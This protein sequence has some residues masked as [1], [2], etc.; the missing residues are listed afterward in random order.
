MTV[1][2]VFFIHCQDDSSF[3]Y[4]LI[5]YHDEFVRDI[6]LIHRTIF[7][8]WDCPETTFLNLLM[9]KTPKYDTTVRDSSKLYSTTVSVSWAANQ[10]IRM[11][12]EGSCDTIIIIIIKLRWALFVTYTIIQSIMRSE[13]CSLNLTHPSVHTPAAVR[14]GALLKGLISV[15]DNSCQSRDSNP[16]PRVTNPMLYPL[17][18]RL[19]RTV[20]YWRSNYAENRALHPS[21]EYITF[22]NIF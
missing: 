1:I 15:R 19:P 13:M 9:L 21:Q 17:E 6:I 12:S 4:M 3:Y 22:Y 8:M 2:T 5:V 14:F 7:Q 20:Y 11:I 10:Y 18:P 16:Q